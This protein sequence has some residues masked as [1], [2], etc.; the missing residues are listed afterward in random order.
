MLVFTRTD[1]IAELGKKN[2]YLCR[3][4]NTTAFVH[5]YKLTDFFW[6]S[7]HIEKYK[8]DV[9]FSLNLSVKSFSHTQSWMSERERVENGMALEHAH[10]Q[11]SQRAT[12]R[13]HTSHEPCECVHPLA[14]T[15]NYDDIVNSTPTSIH[16]ASQCHPVFWTNFI[17]ISIFLFLSVHS[18]T[19]HFP[20]HSYQIQQQKQQAAS[21]SEQRKI[22]QPKNY[23]NK[24][25]ISL[26]FNVNNKIR[27][28]NCVFALVGT[29]R[30]PPNGTHWI[31]TETMARR[32]WS[33]HSRQ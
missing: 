11:F 13:Q 7:R 25:K 21:S 4:E 1:L 20:M 27:G 18:H 30:N 2:I 24:R 22:Q 29:H 31:S 5:R 14:N 6:W 33:A 10:F 17:F 26:L 8:K 32:W 9:C 19:V 23:F 16:T 15:Q 12:A 28:S 3:S